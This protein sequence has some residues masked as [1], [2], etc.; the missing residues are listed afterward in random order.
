M[1]MKLVIWKNDEHKKLIR[2]R[3]CAHQKLTVYWRRWLLTIDSPSTRDY[4]ISMGAWKPCVKLC[5]MLKNEVKHEIASHLRDRDSTLNKDPNFLVGG[6]NGNAFKHDQ[7]YVSL[8][9]VSEM[10]PFLYKLHKMPRCSLVSGAH[11]KILL[12]KPS[13]MSTF[14]IV[15]RRIS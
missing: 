10:G 2:R 8:S 9:V 5:C 12:S 4:I 1:N 6:Q 11:A 14:N 15:K 3:M 7:K 13:K